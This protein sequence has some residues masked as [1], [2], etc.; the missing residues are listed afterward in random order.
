ML[1]TVII[2][3]AIYQSGRGGGIEVSG[4]APWLQ[5]GELAGGWLLP[6]PHPLPQPPQP[7]LNT[8]KVPL[9]PRLETKADVFSAIG[10]AGALV[11]P[12]Y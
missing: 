7:R 8:Q 2:E 10:A 9:G 4:V 5:P 6:H 11:W 12:W 3:F 1:S